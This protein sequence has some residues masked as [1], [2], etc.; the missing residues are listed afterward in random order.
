MHINETTIKTTLLTLVLIFISIA[1]TLAQQYAISGQILNK[2]NK[3]IGLVSVVLIDRD[4]IT[5][6][7]TSSDSL[8]YFILKTEK[9][10]YEFKLEKFGVEYMNKIIEI[11]R[12][13]NS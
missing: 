1:T 5:I 9:G 6:E 10:S 4:S 12:Y 8:G 2:K 13:R 7:K 11:N 3:P